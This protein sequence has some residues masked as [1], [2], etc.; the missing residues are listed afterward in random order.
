MV[1]FYTVVKR[2]LDFLFSFLGLVLLSPFLLILYIFVKCSDVHS[3]VF[4]SHVRNGE[5]GKKFK[6]FKFRTMRT[7]AE[8]VL[9]NDLAL[10]EEFVAN[11]YKLETDKDPRITPIGRILRKTSID[12][13]PQLI[14]VLLGHMSLVG[15]RP[16]PDREIHEY[17]EDKDLFLSVRPGI[18][19]WW[20]VS[21]RSN[22]GY[23]E[24]C[25]L[26]LYYIE[27]ASISFDIYILF[28]TALAVFNRVG[29]H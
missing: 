9:M 15:P 24:R 23:P 5:N 11:G 3:P 25:E 21:G 12:E 29:A 8:A 19:G 10:Y 4:F 13:L 26:E 14:N 27:K 7:D 18:T 20:Q 17:G 1:S 22:V 6:M 16:L 28:K 2:C